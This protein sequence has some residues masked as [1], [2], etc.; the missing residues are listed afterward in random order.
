MYSKLAFRNVLRSAKDYLVYMFTMAVVT[1][2][3]Y[4]FS[5]LLFDKKLTGMFEIAQLMQM[6]TGVATFFIVL[7]VAWLI[8]YM[9]RFMLERRSSEFGIYML[10]GMKKKAIARLY[11]REN[12][13]LGIFAFLP[14]IAAGI[15]LQRF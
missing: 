14:G 13:L 8:N 4:V 2:L 11:M 7:I 15:L 1:A 3:M 12:I 9:V 5:S 10:L 6:M